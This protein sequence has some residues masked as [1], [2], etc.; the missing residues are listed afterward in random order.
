MDLS[1]VASCAV[2][3]DDGDERIEEDEAV[4]I[5]C[6]ESKTFVLIG[7]ISRAWGREPDEKEA[8]IQFTRADRVARQ[9]RALSETC[10]FGGAVPELRS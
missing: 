3:K 8:S 2:T 5:S 7:M 6:F 1:S 4:A 9:A 10:R